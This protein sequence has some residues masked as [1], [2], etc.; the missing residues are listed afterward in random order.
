MSRHEENADY[1]RPKVKR[2]GSILLGKVLI[3]RVRRP[4]TGEWTAAYWELQPPSRTARMLEPL[5]GNYRRRDT[6]VDDVVAAWEADNGGSPEWS[7]R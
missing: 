6:A 5:E 7:D 1:V 3:G 2:D 4:D